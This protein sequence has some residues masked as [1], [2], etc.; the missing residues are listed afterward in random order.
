MSGKY[1]N[2]P[3][4]ALSC[5]D[6][7]WG[8]LLGLGYGALVLMALYQLQLRGHGLLAAGLLLPAL[9][10]L[11]C[12]WRGGGSAGLRLLC[13]ARY[14]WLRDACASAPRP[15]LPDQG[16][17]CLPWLLCIA[18]R[19]QETGARRRL[20]LWAD[21][22]EPSAWRELRRRLTLQG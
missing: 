5:S 3:T 4:L 10:C 22:C 17:I 11:G 21:S 15:V 9:W 18:L 13:G 16:S 12:I 1:S 19:D 7:P 8:R 2:S 6:R 20:W 14:W